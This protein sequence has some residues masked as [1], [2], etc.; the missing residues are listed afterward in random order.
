MGMVW[1]INFEQFAC[2][3]LSVVARTKNVRV[4]KLRANNQFGELQMFRRHTNLINSLFFST[5]LHKQKGKC[6]KL[7]PSCSPPPQKK[8]FVLVDR[9]Q[10]KHLG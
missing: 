10:R 9:G 5:Q 6:F 7:L 2:L 3:M 8:R 4:C 1:F